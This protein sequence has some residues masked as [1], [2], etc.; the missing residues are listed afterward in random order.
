MAL[1][2]FYA[3]KEDVRKISNEL[4]SIIG[5][6]DKLWGPHGMSARELKFWTK[7]RSSLVIVYMQLRHKYI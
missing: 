4:N 2:G 5:R 6:I 1:K 7:Q 3:D